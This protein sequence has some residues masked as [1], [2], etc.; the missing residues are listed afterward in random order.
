MV[1]CIATL[2]KQTDIKITG[3]SLGTQRGS[4]AFPERGFK[5]R[6]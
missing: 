2:K 5:T 6:K 1:K 3:G 4:I